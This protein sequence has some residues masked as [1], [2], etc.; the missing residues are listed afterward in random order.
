MKNVSGRVRLYSP[1]DERRKET[2]FHREHEIKSDN[3]ARE[4]CER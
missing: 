4:D 3:K 1:G 2:E